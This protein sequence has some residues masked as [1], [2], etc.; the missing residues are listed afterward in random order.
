MDWL[1]TN[2]GSVID[3]R[4]IITVN[5][6]Q[7]VTKYERPVDL[8]QL[9]LDAEVGTGASRGNSVSHLTMNVTEEDINSNYE[10]E[11]TEFC[12]EITSKS[13]VNY[14]KTKLEE[15]FH[16]QLKH[17]CTTVDDAGGNTYEELWSCPEG[18]PCESPKSRLS[19][20]VSTTLC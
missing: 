7:S 19:M 4:K 2:L 10:L 12:P 6:A 1:F 15:V 8:L 14:L 3:Q 18:A 11:P 17:D 9:L 20:D 5:T 16:K 13:S